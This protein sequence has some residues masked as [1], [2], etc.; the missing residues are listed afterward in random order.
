VDLGRPAGFAGLSWLL[1]LGER[2]MIDSL[3]KQETAMYQAVGRCI[4]NWAMVEFQLSLIF[5]EALGHIPLVPHN[6]LA[7]I[8]AFDARINIVNAGM[9]TFKREEIK[10]DWL[11]LFKHANNQATLR[12]QI[13][14]ATLVTE[15]EDDGTAKVS[16]EPFFNIVKDR[17]RL[18]VEKVAQ[19]AKEFTELAN[20]L[21]WFQAQLA[22]LETS[23]KKHQM[24]VPRLMLRLRTEADQRRA[25]HGRP[26]RSSRPKS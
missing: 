22:P 11:L 12:N 9:S 17:D 14:H 13:A 3:E 20:T 25:K 6:I 2:G 16:L 7:A 10:S 4:L 24:L 18:D 19:Y 23:P 8:R 15:Y 5:A 26:P 1:A 21:G